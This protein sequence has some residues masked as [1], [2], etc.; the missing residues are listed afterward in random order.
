MKYRVRWE[1]PAV[2][3]LVE[4]ASSRGRQAER[5][6]RGVEQ[7]ARSGA[8]DVKKLEARD[9][10]W[11]LRIGDWRVFFTLDAAGREVAVTAVVLRR[12]AY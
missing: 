8:G 4:I 2:E 5:I 1:T 10:I 7:Y 3:S 6:I 9:N 12:D 11:R